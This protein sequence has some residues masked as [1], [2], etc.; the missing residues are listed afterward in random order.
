LSHGG[1]GGGELTTV[2]APPGPA[3]RH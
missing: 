3:P 1:P 2:K